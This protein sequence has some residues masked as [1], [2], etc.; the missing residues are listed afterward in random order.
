MSSLSVFCSGLAVHYVIYNITQLAYLLCV[1]YPKK[2]K[3]IASHSDLPKK[4]CSLHKST[5]SRLSLW[6]INHYLLADTKAL[7]GTKNEQ[8]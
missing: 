7:K 5:A 4:Y 6:G 8:T 1:S 2:K 3:K